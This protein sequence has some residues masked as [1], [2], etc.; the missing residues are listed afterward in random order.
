MPIHIDGAVTPVV[1]WIKKVSQRK[2][3]GAMSAIAFIVRP[4]RPK[5]FF[6]STAVFSAIHILLRVGSERVIHH[7]GELAP[8]GLVSAGPLARANLHVVPSR[9]YLKRVRAGLG[10]W[11]WG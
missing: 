5:V 4:V 6:I 9:V 11:S 3:P 2:A 8:R 1:A 10:C 7:A